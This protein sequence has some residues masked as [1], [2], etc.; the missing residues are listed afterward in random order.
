M[1][2]KLDGPQNLIL[3]KGWRTVIA[4]LLRYSTSPSR[5]GPLMSRLL[6]QHKQSP[7]IPHL[8]NHSRHKTWETRCFRHLA[9][10]IVP[11]PLEEWDK[12]MNRRLSIHL[13]L[14]LHLRYLGRS[15]TI[16]SWR[17]WQRQVQLF[18]N[19]RN[20][21]KSTGNARRARSLS[22]TSQRETWPYSSRLVI[23]FQSLGQHS[24]V[25]YEIQIS[26]MSKYS[27]IR[28]L[29]VRGS[30][31]SVIP[32]LFPSSHWSFGGTAED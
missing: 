11:I 29:T 19:G 23:Q 30:T 24:M 5:S 27:L 3:S 9:Y 18:A 4:W 16:T 2:S 7:H 28:M 8:N 20:N 10:V 31:V 15:I 32:A 17:R 25:C 6:R 13:T 1:I 21:A 12:L 14:L 26:T 22:E